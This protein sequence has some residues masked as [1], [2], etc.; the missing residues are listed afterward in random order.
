MDSAAA[1][2]QPVA[3]P[4]RRQTV[5]LESPYAA[6]TTIEVQSNVEYARMIQSYAWAEGYT[7]VCPMLLYSQLPTQPYESVC[8][9]ACAHLLPDTANLST[10][11]R[12]GKKGAWRDYAAFRAQ[13][14]VVWACVDFGLSNGMKK[15]LAD[16]GG[17]IRH[18]TFSDRICG[19]L[20][21][22]IALGRATPAQVHLYDR[23]MAIKRQEAESSEKGGAAA[24]PTL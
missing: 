11:Y 9:G 21:S 2:S 24:A 18:Q 13:A 19:D 5:W 12:P 8:A 10:C 6:T 20:V 17:H 23:L 22:P 7:P 3:D 14:D 16:C 1:S 4:P 15:A